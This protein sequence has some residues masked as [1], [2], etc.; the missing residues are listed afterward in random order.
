MPNVYVVLGEANAR[1]SST[2]RT[3]TG[4]PQRKCVTV[5]TNSGDIDIFVQISSLQ[6]SK[7]TPDD[8]I[9]EMTSGGYD[10]VLVTLWISQRFTSTGVYPA[11]VDYLHAFVAAG[12]NIAQIVVLGT[13]TLPSALPAS[14]P[15]PNFIPNSWSTPVNQIASQVRAWWG[16]V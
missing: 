8:F 13:S 9:N 12:W 4:V 14:A 16:W 6:E 3:L 15:S 11:G 10:N 7:I 5:A 2:A 1:K